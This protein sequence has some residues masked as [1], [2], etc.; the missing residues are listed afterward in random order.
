[1]ICHL[2][3]LIYIINHYWPVY[4]SINKSDL[5]KETSDEEY[6]WLESCSTSKYSS[7]R[8][9]MKKMVLA[10]L[11]SIP[12]LSGVS[13]ASS[14]S[15]VETPLLPSVNISA[16][17][18]AAAAEPAAVSAA[19]PDYSQITLDPRLVSVSS[20]RPLLQSGFRSRGFSNSMFEA[21]LLS[22]VALNIADF[23]STKECLKYPHLSEGNPLMKPFVK[24]TAVFAAVKGGLTIASYFGAKAIYK[25]NKPLGWIASIVGNL[26]LS[27]VVTNNFRLL[28]EARAR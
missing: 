20:A 12:L 11:F 8:G 4:C 27:Y 9:Q 15:L 13:W 7:R 14:S 21:S 22:M 26:A 28:N 2:L 25:R 17:L 24:N 16:L 5:L 19:E 23:A 6:Y 18:I 3:T 1:M 10:L